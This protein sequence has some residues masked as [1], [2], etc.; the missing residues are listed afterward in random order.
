MDVDNRFG[1]SVDVNF[2]VTRPF[3]FMIQDITMDTIIFVGQVTNPLSHGAPVV[4][5]PIVNT[6]SQTKRM[7]ELKMK[8]L[9]SIFLEQRFAN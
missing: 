8:N 3:L 6:P 7:C 1:G 5:I 2:E 4:S 9:T